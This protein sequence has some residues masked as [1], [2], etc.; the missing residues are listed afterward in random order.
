MTCECRFK[1]GIQ[2]GRRF[3]SGGQI[4]IATTD[5]DRVRDMEDRDLGWKR[6][7][8]GLFSASGPHSAGERGHRSGQP[9][10]NTARPMLC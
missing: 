9:S 2:P 8:A 3:R 4:G 5:R 7:P 10:K 1:A 6:M